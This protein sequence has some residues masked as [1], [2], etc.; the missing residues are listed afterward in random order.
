MSNLNFTPYL[1][2]D[3]L[4]EIVRS[5]VSSNIAV[6]NNVAQQSNQ[7]NLIGHVDSGDTIGLAEF[8]ESAGVKPRGHHHKQRPVTLQERLKMLMPRRVPLRRT[9]NVMNP[10]DFDVSEQLQLAGS[11]LL[12]ALQSGDRSVMDEHLSENYDP[13][14]RYALLQYTRS[15]VDES[16]FSQAE[17]SR[18]ANDLDGMLNELMNKDGDVIH[19]GLLNKNA[20][21]SAL[22]RMS[23]LAVQSN[24]EHPPGSLSELRAMY[25]A[26]PK[27]KTESGLTAIDL[28]KSLVA[29]FGENNFSQALSSLR[30]TMSTDFRNNP[31]KQSGPKLWLSLTDA[32]S[33]NIVQTGFALA[34]DLRRNL[35]EHAGVM[36][37]SNQAEMAI[38]LLSLAEHGRGKADHLMVHLADIQSLTALQK[39]QMCL[40]TRQTIE[41]FPM[42]FW[43]KE[44]PLQRMS[45]LDELG[46]L[47]L[48]ISGEIPAALTKEEQLEQAMRGKVH[49]K[50][51][52]GQHGG[53]NSHDSQ[54]NQDDEEDQQNHVITGAR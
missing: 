36:T 26:G 6:A 16:D 52:Q 18:L 7:M 48:A 53:G 40:L 15:K 43:K 33:F 46:A 4:S 29:K 47:A 38:A 35:S 14:E 37:K 41:K 28:A 25:G 27:G 39:M 12:E 44:L 21:E 34:G 42:I 1:N 23:S 49:R 2:V 10:D 8:N 32:N 19:T 51:K 3:S 5:T 30:S 11:D 31:A 9:T 45:L 20:F 17:K 54:P 24:I 50:T 13:L 22:G